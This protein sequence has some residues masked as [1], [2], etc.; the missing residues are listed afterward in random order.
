M[1]SA[2]QGVFRSNYWGNLN[3]VGVEARP[4]NWLHFFMPSPSI[5]ESTQAQRIADRV[6]QGSSANDRH[7]FH[8]SYLTPAVLAR[9]L[10][11]WLKLAVA[12]GRL[13]RLERVIRE[14]GGKEWLWTLVRRDMRESLAGP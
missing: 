5:R 8:E 11:T 13:F 12:R 7:C 14:L 10:A 2:E 3:K 6:N 1:E 4:I 9:V